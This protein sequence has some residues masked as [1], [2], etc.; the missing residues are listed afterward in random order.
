VHQP[1]IDIDDIAGHDAAKRG[2]EICAAGGH[3]LLM[4]GPPGSGK[5]MLA[6]ALC[7]L[8]PPLTDSECLETALV[9]SVAGLEATQTLG[10]VRPFR[11]P[12][13]SSSVAGLIGG[14]SPPRPGELSL[15]HNGVLFL[16]E[17]PEFPPAALQALRQPL[18][19]GTVTLVRAYGMVR[20]PA[21]VTFVAAMNPC[22]CGMSGDPDRS[23]SCAPGA[24]SRYVSRVGGPLYDRMDLTLRIDRVD[25]KRLIEDR[26][27]NGG[28]QAACTRIVAAR[29]FARRRP[30][31]SLRATLT[32][33][34]CSLLEQ[35]ARAAHL[36]GRAVTRI[37]RVARTIADLDQAASVGTLHVSEALGYRGW[38]T[39]R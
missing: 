20:Y 12:H 19:Q 4:V 1:D 21:R 30:A 6:R 10:G 28:S 32:P 39:Q 31:L 14:G 22:P 8:L 7:G 2:L 27:R 33:A 17:L 13:H 37:M 23:C 5:T 24:I 35:A 34:A 18:E 25:P 9:H 26:S 38:D 15:A 11:A 3:N 16:D 29:E 36:S